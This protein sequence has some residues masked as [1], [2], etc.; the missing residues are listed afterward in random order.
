VPETD[1]QAAPE[2]FVARYSLTKLIAWAALSGGMAALCL[3]FAM[4]R[5]GLPGLIGLALGGSG[6]LF[7]GTIGAVH[8]VRL[9]DRR[10]QVIIDKRGVYVRSHGEKRIGLRSIK[11]LHRDAGRL[12][13]T[14]HKPSKYPIE[15]WHRR[16]I[17]R[18]NGSAA[19]EFFGDMWIWTNQIDSSQ[20][21]L[22]DAILAHRP[23][24]DFER[25]IA[26][27]I[28]ANR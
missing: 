18:I 26:E 4:G 15:R 9:F 22:I 17:Y 21:A 14:F 11:G 28:A 10:P 1:G 5:F 19:R 6:A 12:S 16:L 25:E 20:T 2:A 8:I 13:V 27:I 7:F 23:Q 3:A 24:T